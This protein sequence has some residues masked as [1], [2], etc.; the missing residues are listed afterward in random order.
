MNAFIFVINLSLVLALRS[1]NVMIYVLYGF[2]IWAHTL[3]NKNSHKSLVV[4]F[5]F[6]GVLLWFSYGTQK[7]YVMQGSQPSV[8]KNT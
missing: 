4:V 6:V 7:I 2:S 1:V 8:K 3:L 5:A